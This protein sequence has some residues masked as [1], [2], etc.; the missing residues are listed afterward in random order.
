MTN[1]TYTDISFGYDKGD[2]ILKNIN[3]NF[4]TK[5]IV[6]ILG[7]N[8]GG[9]TT[10]LKLANGLLRPQSGK[11]FLDN[12]DIGDFIT[13]QLSQRILVTFQFTRQQFFTSTVEKELKVTISQYK[14]DTISQLQ[15][16]ERILK[17]LELIDLR[18][19]HPYILSGGE[20]RRL[21]IA[22]T[23]A[24]SALFF[25]L[26]EPTANLDHKSFELLV[27]LLQEMRNQG[28]GIVIVSHD[29]SFQLA[30]CDRLIVLNNGTIEFS[31][32]PFELIKSVKSKKWNFLDLPEI[33][34]FI[35]RLEPKKSGNELLKNY[36]IC[37]DLEEKTQAISNVLEKI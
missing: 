30:L 31:G 34:Q 1:L 2:F 8:G 9:K 33:F 19:Y 7:P 29:L 21:A 20:Q 26:D 24:S 10:L 4:R 32:T 15:H 35:Q 16:L 25:L 18:D 5:E 17:R 23:L 13:S 11:I 22:T 37:E 3:L 12:K 14:N 36:I 28:K 27:T 6:G